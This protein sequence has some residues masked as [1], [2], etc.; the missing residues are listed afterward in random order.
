MRRWQCG[1]GA[2]LAVAGMG[3][4][5]AQTPQILCD[6]VRKLVQA[7]FEPT[8]FGSVVANGAPTVIPEQ[9]F[10]ECYYDAS[11][12]SYSCRLPVP[13]EQMGAAHNSLGQIL[14]VCLEVAPSVEQVEP[15]LFKLPFISFVFG[16]GEGPSVSV[17]LYPRQD[18]G[19]YADEAWD[20]EF[21]D[22]GFDLI[23]TRLI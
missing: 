19:I 5:Q 6:N 2:V 3:S 18:W 9:S 13:S 21:T 4:A 15:G 16:P 1:L 22:F 10:R 12:P 23:V 17:T 7:A 20:E 11:G 14:T 8:A